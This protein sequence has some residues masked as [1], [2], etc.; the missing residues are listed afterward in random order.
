MQ[1]I[2]QTKDKQTEMKCKIWRSF[3][4]FKS[5]W[6]FYIWNADGHCT[7]NTSFKTRFSPLPRNA[8]HWPMT[9]GMLMGNLCF[10]FDS[11]WVFFP[12]ASH[13]LGKPAILI[14]DRQMCIT[15]RSL[16]FN[17]LSQQFPDSILICIEN[18]KK[19]I[20]YWYQGLRHIGPLCRPYCTITLP[21]WKSGPLGK[22]VTSRQT[23]F[24][25][26][27]MLVIWTQFPWSKRL[28][29]TSPK[30]TFIIF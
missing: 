13:F 28:K 14:S 1:D 5:S 17:R 10:S 4:N 22:S 8:Y 19:T 29:L 9:E 7:M 20:F 23:S 18:V 27:L 24:L 26:V 2:W 11:W 3:R 16:W 15:S 12:S 25:W 30:W 21:E 6:S